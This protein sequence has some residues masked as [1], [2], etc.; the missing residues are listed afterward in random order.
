MARPCR[1]ARRPSARPSRPR[2]PAD[3]PGR[4]LPRQHRAD[5]EPGGMDG[6]GSDT[7]VRRVHGRVAGA[8]A[9]RCSRVR[10]AEPQAATLA[11]P[12]PL[13][14]GANSRPWASPG[15]SRLSVPVRNDDALGATGGARGVDHVRSWSLACL[16]RPGV[17]GALLRR[18]PRVAR[19][20]AR[21][22]RRG[23]RVGE[24][25]RAGGRGEARGWARRGARLVMSAPA[26]RADPRA[27][28]GWR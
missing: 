25:R 14:R 10:V 22:A 24:E 1:P 17:A 6:P 28:P 8:A 11:R 15:I 26:M 27:R 13:G 9:C 7:L 12:R 18:E 21:R 16:I 19:P 20:T 3:G 2:R 4:A 5:A 23:A